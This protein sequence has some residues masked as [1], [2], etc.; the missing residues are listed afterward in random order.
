[1]RLHLIVSINA[2]SET[3]RMGISPWFHSLKICRRGRGLAWQSPS[4]ISFAATSTGEPVRRMESSSAIATAE[5][6][7]SFLFLPFFAF[8]LPFFSFFLP[9]REGKYTNVFLKSQHQAFV[10]FGQRSQITQKG[11][12]T[13]CKIDSLCKYISLLF[14]KASFR[15]SKAMLLPFKRSCFVTQKLCF[16]SMKP[17]VLLAFCNILKSD[18]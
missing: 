1:M 7:L 13:L 8:F 10:F 2:S 11:Q 15:V 14:Q 4:T 9:F 17:Q 12:S 6:A 16:C 3:V 5:S 18:F